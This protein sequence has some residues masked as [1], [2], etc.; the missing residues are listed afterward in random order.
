METDSG[1][2]GE[3]E[4]QMQVGWGTVQHCGAL[5]WCLRGPRDRSVGLGKPSNRLEPR[6]VESACFGGMRP[7]TK[8]QENREEEKPDYALNLGSG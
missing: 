5:Q 6:T 7:G 4:P 1:R 3:G 2:C 8:V